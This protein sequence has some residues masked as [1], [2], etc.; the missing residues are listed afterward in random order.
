MRRQV[1]HVAVDTRVTIAEV[2]PNSRSALSTIA[3]NTGCTSDGE[4]AMT[5][6]ISAV[7][8]C[9]SSASLVSLNRRTFSIAI[10]AW[11]A[12]VLQQRDLLLASADR[13]ARAIT[14][15]VPM[16]SSV[17]QH[18]HDRDRASSRVASEVADSQPR[19]ARLHRPR[20]PATSITMPSRMA[21]A[22]MY[23]RVSGNRWRCFALRRV[24]G[25]ARRDRREPCPSPSGRVTIAAAFGEQPQRALH[26]GSNT[27]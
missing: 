13:A 20:H 21:T 23:S 2:P 18:R 3:S 26:D 7:A 12:K 16:A 24:D 25:S 14:L 1:Q 15:I 27:G 17:A 11:S 9:R 19:A 10:T 5:L 4:L 6:R 22:C 8:V